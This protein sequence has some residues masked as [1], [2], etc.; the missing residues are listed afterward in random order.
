MEAALL[1]N[2]IRTL[3]GPISC[4]HHDV[5]GGHGVQNMND[6]NNILSCIQQ[7]MP[8]LTPPYAALDDGIMAWTWNAFTH[9]IG[10][11]LRQL[12]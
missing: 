1:T 3:L 2:G 6:L 9:I 11:T 10:H 8:A 7:G 4:R 12:S 5:S